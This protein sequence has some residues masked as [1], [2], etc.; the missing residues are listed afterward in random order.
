MFNQLLKKLFIC[1][2]NLFDFFQNQYKKNNGNPQTRE[3]R[4]DTFICTSY[5]K[6]IKERV[7]CYGGGKSDNNHKKFKNLSFIERKTDENSNN[8]RGN[9]MEQGSADKSQISSRYAC[10]YVIL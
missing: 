6:E 8:R 1:R 5:Y 4:K 7:Q 2:F 3:H 9:D 10:Y